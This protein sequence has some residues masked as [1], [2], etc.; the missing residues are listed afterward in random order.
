M[1]T[2]LNIVAG[3]LLLV[4]SWQKHKEQEDAQK[5]ADKINANPTDWF[6]DHFSSGVSVKSAGDEA[7]GKATHISIDDK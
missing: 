3:L 5:Q 1:N 7:P 2:V 6:N 4:Q